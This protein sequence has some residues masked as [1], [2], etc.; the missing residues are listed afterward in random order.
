MIKYTMDK[1]VSEKITF[2]G[3]VFMLALSKKVFSGKTLIGFIFLT[4]V[5]STV[6]V[7]VGFIQAPVAASD[8]DMFTRV[9]GDYLF[10]LIQ[11]VLGVMAML[12]PNLMKH[13]LGISVP[14]NMLLIYAIVLYCAIYLGEIRSFYYIFPH[15]DTI[16]HTFTGAMLG[17]LGFSTINFLNK[18]D[19]FHM[20]LSP[21]FVAVFA[22]CF[23]V[24]L[25]VV[26]EVYEFSIDFFLGTNMQKFALENKE[27]LVGQVA[28]MDTM[29]DLIV[30]CMGAF[31]MATIGFISL[32]YN[33]NWIES[34]MLT[35]ENE[36]NTVDLLKN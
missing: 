6:Y 23:A 17:A 34:M 22:F 12:L 9:K 27:L 28:L 5:V 3:D 25:G 29:K 4:L 10:M 24:T 7:A 20:N 1:K 14:S 21:I 33:K 26:W 36:D 30:D 2:W 15:W 31:V 18:V 19:K 32:K 8:G 11:C 13:K 35:F 16:L